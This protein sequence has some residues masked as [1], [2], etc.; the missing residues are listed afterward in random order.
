MSRRTKII[1]GALLGVLFLAI[2]IIGFIVN[3]SVF[4]PP[5]VSEKA[6]TP[7]STPPPSGA[8]ASIPAVVPIVSPDGASNL[9]AIARSFAERYGSF[10]NQGNFENIEDLYPFMTA[11][12]RSDMEKTV[13]DGRL[14]RD[15]AAQGYFGIT[16]RAL[17]G[18]VMEQSSRQAVVAITT[19]R[20]EST[21]E[22]LNAKVYNQDILITLLEEGGV[23]RVDR[24]SW[25]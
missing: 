22:Q 18:R 6:N 11:S 3:S 24:V 14:R 5:S 7:A 1:L 2:A 15:D 20:R 17:A 12:L 10:S 21:A 25:K 13:A 23:W 8:S 19:Q 9:E 16:T 4:A